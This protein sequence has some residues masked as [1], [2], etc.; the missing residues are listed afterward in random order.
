MQKTSNSESSRRQWTVREP[1]FDAQRFSGGWSCLAAVV[2]SQFNGTFYSE[3]TIWRV[4]C[5]SVSVPSLNRS[6][7]SSLKLYIFHTSASFSEWRT[8]PVV[9]CSPVALQD[10]PALHI[11]SVKEIGGTIQGTKFLWGPCLN[12]LPSVRE[13]TQVRWAFLTAGVSLHACSGAGSGFQFGRLPSKHS[14]EMLVW[15]VCSC[16]VGGT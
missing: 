7:F 16:K 9:A 15:Q 10:Q 8:F 11:S 12:I 13:L 2:C 4:L 3:E 6:R 1:H 14:E 5:R